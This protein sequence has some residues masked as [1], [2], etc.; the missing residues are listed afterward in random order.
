MKRLALALLV[1]VGMSSSAF[2]QEASN[3]ATTKGSKELAASKVNGNFIFVLPDNVTSDQ[4]TKSAKYYTHYFSV[5]FDVDSHTVKVEMK[6]NT[7]KGRYVIAR[8]L[9]S[10]GVRYL[11]VDSENLELYD[12]LDK[13]LK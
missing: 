2:S 6:D 5:D 4:V 10:C 1:L 13:H 12:F 11:A 8:F 3:I 9:S 7:Q